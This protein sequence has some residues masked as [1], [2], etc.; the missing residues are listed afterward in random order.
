[1]KGGILAKQSGQAMTEFVVTV[2]YVFLGLLVIVPT[3]GKIMDLQFQTQ[4]ASRYVAWERTVWFDQGDTPGASKQSSAYWESV[5]TRDDDDLMS[6]MEN[7]FF[8]GTGTGILRPITN[9]DID[10]VTAD[11]SPIWTY[12]QSGNSMYGGTV[13]VDESLDNQDT[14]SVAYKIIDV[15]DDGMEIIASPLNEVLNF[16]GGSNEDFL[17]LGYER[18]NYFSPVIQT[19]LNVGNSKGGGTGKWDR[20]ADG[21]MGSGIEDAIFQDWD[22][23]IEMR[24]AILADGWNTQSLDHYQ[25]R[26]DDFVLTTM[27]KNDLIDT[28]ILAASFLDGAIGSLEFGAVGIE[29][30]PAEDGEALEVDCDDGFCYYDD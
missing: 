22:G 3:F 2:S 23:K 25:E 27:F 19:Q 20:Q 14:P 16:L 5:A 7:R 13:L 26:A 18:E 15:I 28:V 30:M 1:M 11:A 29:P 6:S 24:S 12:V 10:A 8:Y 4:Q 21:S 17:S 9:S